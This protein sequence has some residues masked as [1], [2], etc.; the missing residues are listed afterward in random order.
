MKKY[1]AAAVAVFVLSSF[2][3]DILRGDDIDDA[4]YLSEDDIQSIELALP[5]DVPE[6]PAQA[7]KASEAARQTRNEKP[8]LNN[9]GK[10]YQLLVLDRNS[11]EPNADV[12]GI[13]ETDILYK[14]RHSEKGYLILLRETP[15]EGPVFPILP[16]Y[17]YI[18]LELL[19]NRINTLIEY[20]NSDQFKRFV[21]NEEILLE[22]DRSLRAL[23]Q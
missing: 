23:R 3:P 19:S 8:R 13:D 5:E 9:R 16:E 10:L 21:S 2:S 11:C 14:F 15:E 4:P 17:S 6:K 7:N 1:L 22:L 12:A 18:I 20:I